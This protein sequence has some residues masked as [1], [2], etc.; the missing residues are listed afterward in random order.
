MFGKKR[1]QPSLLRRLAYFVLLLSGGGAGI[2]GYALK[3]HP[4]VQAILTYL[5]GESGK[6]SPGDVEKGLVADV[7]GSSRRAR[8][9]Q[10]PAS[11]K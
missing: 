5:A 1:K 3:D 10:R 9:L 6:E 11:I 2:G 4:T 8:I 7:V